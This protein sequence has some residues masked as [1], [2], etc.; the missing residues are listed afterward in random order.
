MAAIAA[1][2]VVMAMYPGPLNVGTRLNADTTIVQG[3]FIEMF[4]TAMLVFTYIMLGCV[5][6]RATFLA[7]LGVGLTG[8]ITHLSGEFVSFSSSHFDERKLTV[9][10]AFT[11]LAR[12]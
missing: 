12:R 2:A 3:F 1:A 9:L 7:P 10:Q 5:K 8:F 11:S 4:L 6:H